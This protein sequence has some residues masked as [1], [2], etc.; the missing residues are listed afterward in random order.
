[1]LRRLFQRLFWRRSLNFYLRN[2]LVPGDALRSVTVL[3]AMR[4]ANLVLA[5]ESAGPVGGPL[6]L[7][8]PHPDDE[9]IGPGGTLIGLLERGASVTVA[10]LTDGT[11]D[12][13]RALVRRAE[14]RASAK[15]LGF[16][17]QFFGL[18]ADGIPLDEGAALLEHLLAEMRPAALMLPFVLDDNDD[19]RRA[20]ELLLHLRDLPADLPIWA[21]QVYTSL[22]A[23]RVVDITNLADEKVRAINRYTSQVTRRDWAHF[24]L[25]LNAMN[26]RML[27][28]PGV[29][30]VEAF[31]ALPAA[32]YVALCESYFGSDA[33]P[34]YLGSRY[35]SMART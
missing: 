7:L 34:C 12:P 3:D 4:S 5:E 30:Y 21:Y 1:M 32:R 24:A 33:Q 22:P 27:S 25:G 8:A 10:F 14:A 16:H 17:A 28:K 19:H 23:N 26:I 31:L 6:L 11:I 2:W 18:P 20:S 13:E 9:V 29:R 35:R 15:A